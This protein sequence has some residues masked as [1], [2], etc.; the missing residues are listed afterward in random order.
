MRLRKGLLFGAWRFAAK[1][2]QVAPSPN[3]TNPEPAAPPAD[4]LP[5]KCRERK[6]NRSKTEG[7][8]A[9][10]MRVSSQ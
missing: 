8:E 10:Q 7:T 2:G 9:P 6:S 4:A 5:F 3:E 1:T